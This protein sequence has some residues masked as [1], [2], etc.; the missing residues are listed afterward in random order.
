MGDVRIRR[1]ITRDLTPVEVEAIRTILWSA[2]A[3]DE[4]GFTEDDW[5]HGLGGTHVVAED[6]GRIVGHGS[7]VAR[8]IRFGGLALAAG[9][10]EAVATEPARQG[11]GIGS[12]VIREVNVIVTEGHEIGVLGTGEQGFYERLGWR[13][14]HGPSS[15]RTAEGERPTPDDDGYLMVLV[16]PKTPP[17][18]FDAPISCDW[19]PGD[20]W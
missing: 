14:W 1:A 7:V 13:T 9:Y 20:A 17:L 4:E 16:L 2:F 18:D 6:E 5:Q 8:T 10:V 12:A 15:V 11:T 19:R 3:G